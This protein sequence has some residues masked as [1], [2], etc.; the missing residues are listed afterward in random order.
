MGKGRVYKASVVIIIFKH[1]IVIV[2]I[3]C[4]S[5]LGTCKITGKGRFVT[6]CSINGF[7]CICL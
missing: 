5:V 1:V 4:A 7:M 2:D 3:F 6:L